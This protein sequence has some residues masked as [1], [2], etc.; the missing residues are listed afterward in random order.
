MHEAQPTR[1]EVLNSKFFGRS[2]A[3][4]RGVEQLLPR[5][6][7][8]QQQCGRRAAPGPGPGPGPDSNCWKPGRTQ[9]LDGI[10]WAGLGVV[11]PEKTRQSRGFPSVTAEPRH[12]HVVW[13][14]GGYLRQRC[15]NDV[16]KHLDVTEGPIHL[17]QYI[18]INT[19]VFT[20]QLTAWNKKGAFSPQRG[21][22]CCSLFKQMIKWDLPSFI[23]M[24]LMIKNN[25]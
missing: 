17:Y 2:S 11:I 22:T 24:C 5:P 4:G 13:R 23:S 9:Q 7:E 25:H 6:C 21:N 19:S 18:C 15:Q 16:R 1:D 14:R 12:G 3:D 20:D 10:W 8:A